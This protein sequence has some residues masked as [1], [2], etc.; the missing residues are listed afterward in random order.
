MF[1]HGA[2]LDAHEEMFEFI[3][4]PLGTEDGWLFACSIATAHRAS[5]VRPVRSGRTASTIK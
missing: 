2:L 1:Q 5:G 4:R 3:E